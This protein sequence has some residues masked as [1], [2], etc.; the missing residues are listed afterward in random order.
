MGDAFLKPEESIEIWDV[1]PGD[2]IADFGCGSGYFSIPLGKRVGAMGKV[3]A[4]D[5]RTEAL[6]ATRAKLKLF[7][8]FNIEPARADLE[9]ERGSGLKSE[10]V[11]KILIANILFQAE[12]KDAVVGEAFR[13]LR[14]GGTLMAVEWN[15]TKNT[16][17]PALSERIPRDVAE[18]MFQR[19]GF[20]LVKEFPAGSHHYGLIFKK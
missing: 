9:R 15:E 18:R 16:A 10:S 6:E 5:I 19:A 4:L 8:L 11:D 2:K 12:N 13:V 7:H 20:S 14:S 3:Y 17:G 1:R